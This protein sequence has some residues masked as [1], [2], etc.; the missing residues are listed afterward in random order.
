MCVGLQDQIDVHFK[1][2]YNRYGYTV[3]STRVSLAHNYAHTKAHLLPYMQGDA[4]ELEGKDDQADFNSLLTSMEVLGVKKKERAGIFNI[5]AA[6]LHLGNMYFRNES[7]SRWRGKVGYIG[8]HYLLASIRFSP[9]F[10]LHPLL[11]LLHLLIIS[12]S[13]SPSSFCSSS[14]FKSSCFPFSYTSSS[15]STPSSFYF[16]S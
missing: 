5:L 2:I 12:F 1:Y 3:D 4:C 8:V 10:L 13:F 16:I 14:S 7:V 11:F 15:S 6:I 9:L